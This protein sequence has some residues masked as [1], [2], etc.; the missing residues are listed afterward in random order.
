MKRQGMALSAVLALVACMF[1]LGLASHAMLS[2]A[3]GRVQAHQQTQIASGM[4]EAGVEYARY[5]VR[6]GRWSTLRRFTSPPFEGGQ[7]FTVDAFPLGGGRFRI[8]SV[9]EAGG[10]RQSREAMA[11]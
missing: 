3:R 6:H 7:R 4:A 2:V 8:V 10:A 5:Q 1:A 11:P 9:G